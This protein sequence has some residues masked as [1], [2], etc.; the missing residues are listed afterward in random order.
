MERPLFMWAIDKTTF[1]SI[2]ENF[3]KNKYLARRK[4]IE[5]V[6]LFDDLTSFQRDNICHGLLEHIYYEDERIIS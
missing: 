2:N 5:T 1:R 6:P 4:Y 3:G